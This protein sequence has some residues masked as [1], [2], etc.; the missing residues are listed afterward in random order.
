MGLVFFEEEVRKTIIKVKI[1][2]SIPMINRG[3]QML[4]S[5]TQSESALRSRG[6]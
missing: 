6:I 1:K 2:N 4:F 5:T 3:S